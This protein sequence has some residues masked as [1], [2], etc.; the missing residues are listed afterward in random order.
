MEVCSEDCEALRLRWAFSDTTLVL[1]DMV[2]LNSP[3][4]T[5]LTD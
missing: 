3:G 1:T 2:M 5:A 4:G